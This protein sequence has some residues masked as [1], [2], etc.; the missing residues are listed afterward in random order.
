MKAE[1][2]K[3]ASNLSPEENG[4]SLEMPFASGFQVS[5][6]ILPAPASPMSGFPSPPLCCT[7]M[8]L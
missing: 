3:S 2:E 8:V 4:K 1:A 7:L 5:G 6:F